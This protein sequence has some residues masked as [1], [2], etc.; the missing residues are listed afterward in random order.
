MSRPLIGITTDLEPARWGDWVREAIVSPASYARAVARAG[1]LPIAIPPVSPSGAAD[2][3]AGMGALVVTG[4]MDM[5]PDLYGEQPHEATSAGDGNRDRFELAMVRAAM[6]ADLPLLAIGRGLH[7][8]NI[9]CGGS[10]IQH[11]PDVV[12][13]QRHAPDPVKYGTHEVQVSAGSTL[14]HIVGDR[15]AAPTRHHQ[16]VHRLGTGLLAVAW[17]DDQIVEAA[18]LQG[19]PFALGV[20]W[21][22]EEGDDGRLFEALV[23]AAG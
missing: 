21:H 2:L 5:Q 17:A 1:G 19:S 18:E 7:V 10:L 13:H 16:A 22:P 6:E 15:V 20:Q 14:G 4:G 9:A 23:A 11:L 3:A 12:D 8:F